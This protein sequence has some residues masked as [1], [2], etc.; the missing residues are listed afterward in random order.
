M[1]CY[2]WAGCERGSAQIKA[3]MC[4]CGEAAEAGKH[5]G[6]GHCIKVSRRHQKW[7]HTFLSV[8]AMQ[9]PL[10]LDKRVLLLFSYYE[11]HQCN[12]AGNTPAGPLSCRKKPPARHSHA[13][14]PGRYES[15]SLMQQIK[16]WTLCPKRNLKSILR[17]P[18]KLFPIYSLHERGPSLTGQIPR[19]LKIGSINDEACQTK[20]SQKRVIL[21]DYNI[22]MCFMLSARPASLPLF[23]LHREPPSFTFCHSFGLELRQTADEAR[24]HLLR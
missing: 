2:I 6:R 11:E 9:S 5:K 15:S 4:Q 18:C 12:R 14:W 10:L 22:H 8:F 16:R 7:F 17:H 20:A 3:L 23:V 24:A 13:V 21:Y 19:K 1:T